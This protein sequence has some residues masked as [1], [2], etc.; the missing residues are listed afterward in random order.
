MILSI[1]NEEEKTL[2]MIPATVEQVIKKDW[3]NMSFAEKVKHLEVEGY[4]MMP[5]L[6]TPE[7]IGQI[8]EELSR[9]TLR[10]APYSDSHQLG[11]NIQ[12]TDSPHTID[13]IANPPIIQFLD[14]LFGDELICTSCTYTLSKPGHPGTAIH[15]DAQPYGSAIFGKQASAPR[16]IRVLYYLDDLTVE[17]SP[18]L[19]IPRSHLSMHADGNPYHRYLGHPESKAAVCKAGTAAI[20]NQNIFHG[21]F[22]NVSNEDRGLLAIAYRPAWAGP[23]ED[24]EDWDAQKVAQL[25]GHVRQFFKSLNTRKID[26]YVP[27]RSSDFKREAPGINPSRWEH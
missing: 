3:G 22:P 12:W 16:L 8:K 14:K 23:I 11:D 18:L 24:S 4:L 27:N 25:P 19:V 1:L 2:D 20:I 9:L 26:F 6:L 5:D 13:V 7:Q 15:T 10:K 21:N 17:K